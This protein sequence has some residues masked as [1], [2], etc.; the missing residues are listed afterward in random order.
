MNMG[1][2]EIRRWVD[3][4]AGYPV[5]RKEDLGRMLLLKDDRKE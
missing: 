1:G 3:F 2:K 4:Y 5:L